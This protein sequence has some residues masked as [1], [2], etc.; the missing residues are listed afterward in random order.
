MLAPVSDI[1]PCTSAL[2]IFLPFPPLAPLPTR[3]EAS[4]GMHAA[5]RTQECTYQGLLASCPH[6]GPAQIACFPCP[7]AGG[8]PTYTL[9]EDFALGMELCKLRWHCR[10]VQAYLA[11]GEAPEQIRNCYQQRSRWCKVGPRALTH[12]HSHM[13]AGMQ[14]RGVCICMPGRRCLHI[15]ICARIH[16]RKD[17][18]MSTCSC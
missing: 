10:Y 11:L 9:T 18:Q 13:Q 14:P 1:H 15:H 4:A 8:S 3:S 16:S 2:D 5:T 12:A 17:I 7:Q 6:L